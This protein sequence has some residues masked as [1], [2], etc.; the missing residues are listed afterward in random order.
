MS[1]KR[2]KQ[3]ISLGLMVFLQIA[4]CIYTTSGIAAKLA[5]QH[6]F[7]SFGFILCYG[8]EILILGIYAILWQQ[9]IKRVDLS[10]AY[11]NRSVA[12]FWS[13]LWSALI[14]HEQITIPEIMGVGLIFLGTWMVNSD[15]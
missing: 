10:V 4:I 11:A 12:I 2:K 9:I 6:E 15:A 3:K 1:E 5:S 13:M 7:L 14:F 8:I